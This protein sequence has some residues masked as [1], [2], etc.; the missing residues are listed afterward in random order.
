MSN[1]LDPLGPEA[2]RRR[3]AYH[4]E[5]ALEHIQHAETCK[6]LEKGALECL[7]RRELVVK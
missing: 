7:I 3:K 1:L 6:E 2:L 4:L 5:Q